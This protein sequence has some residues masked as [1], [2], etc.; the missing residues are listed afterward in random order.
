MKCLFLLFFFFLPGKND[1]PP[2]NKFSDVWKMGIHGPVKSV[3]ISTYCSDDLKRVR[4]ILMS[5]RTFHFSPEGLLMVENIDTYRYI[6][7]EDTLKR[8]CKH[9]RSLGAIE[10]SSIYY[11]TDNG[12][13]QEISYSFMGLITKTNLYCYDSQKN[14][15]HIRSTT[16]ASK[17]L[18]PDTASMELS[19]PT[20]PQIQLQPDK[21]GNP[22]KAILVDTYNT[23]GNLF[24]DSITYR[25]KYTY[26]K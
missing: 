7:S 15:Q 17:L 18:A 11:Y 10:D 5:A 2:Q 9:Y 25:Y 13:I 20:K 1:M 12:C 22:R 14:L 16:K 26:Y 24:L 23:D 19:I 4:K 21:Y 3:K 8:I 6:L